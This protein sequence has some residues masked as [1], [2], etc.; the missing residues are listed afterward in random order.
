MAASAQL[1]INGTTGVVAAQSIIETGTTA[2]TNGHAV[3]ATNSGTVTNSGP[4]T[5]TTG[6]STAYGVFVQTGASAFFDNAT[7]TT[8]GATAYGLD[9]YNAGSE[10]RLRDSAV[11]TSGRGSNGVRAVGAGTINLTDV[12]VSTTGNGSYGIQSSGANSRVNAEGVTVQTTGTAEGANSSVGAIAEGGGTLVL[13]HSSANAT[14][15]TTA[16]AQASGLWAQTEGALVATG[17][18]RLLEVRT[19]GA[20]AYGAFAHGAGSSMSLTNVDIVTQGD[21]SQGVHADIGA[22]ITLT[23]DMQASRVTT[24]GTDSAGVWAENANASLYLANTDV[25]TSGQRAIGAGVANGARLEINGGSVLTTGEGAIGAMNN[26][27]TAV[28]ARSANGSGTVIGTRGESSHGI[29]VIANG[30][31]RADGATISTLGDLAA[32]ARAAAG[33]SLT[34]TNSTIVTEGSRGYGMTAIDPGSVIQ[35]NNVQVTTTGDHLGAI[36]AAGVVSEFGAHVAI[37][38]DSSVTT[39]GTRAIGLLS[40]VGGDNNQPD[41]VLTFNGGSAA[42]SVT[43]LG[44]MAHGAMVCSRSAGS[45]DCTAPLGNDIAGAGARASMDINGVS[46]ST[47]GSSAYGLVAFGQSAN[48]SAQHVRVDTAGQDAHASVVRNGGQVSIS[49]STLTATGANAA[50]VF[51]TGPADVNGTAT[52]SNVILSAAQGASV[53]VDGGTADLSLLNSKAQ[54]NDGRWLT[55]GNGQVADASV[56][57]ATLDASIV[58]GA[59]TTAVGSTS[60]VILRNDTDWEMTA[61]SNVSNLTNNDS[62]IRFSAPGGVPALAS[63]YKTLTVANYA[64]NGGDIG[65]NTYLGADG[66]PSDRLVVDGGAASGDTGLRIANTGGPG[67]HT[68]VNGIQVVEAANGGV[69]TAGAFTLRNRVVAGP[70]EYRLIRGSRDD[71]DEQGW[72][73]RS[74]QEVKPPVES[75]PEASPDKP[76][77]SA[78]RPLYRPE[79]AAYLANQ[80]QAIGMFVHSLHDRLGEPQWLQAGKQNGQEDRRGSAWMRV[81]AKT[82]DATSRH[83]DFGAKSDSTLIQGGGDIARWNIGGEHA[84]L[85]LGG[86]LGY[87]EARSDASATGNSAKARGKTEGWNVGA[88]GTWYQ[89]DENKLGWYADAWATYGRFKNTV[90]GDSMPQVRYDSDVLTLSAETGYA[91]KVRQDSDWIIEP[92]AQ[93]IFIRYGQDDVAE[94][95]GTRITD[96]NDRNGW[97]SRLGVR[98]HRTWETSSGKLIQPYLTLNW[99]RDNTSNALAFNGVT[100]G[101]LLPK[102]RYEAKAGINA[103]LGSGWSVWGNVGHQLGSQ[104]YSETT[105]RAGAKYTW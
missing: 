87:G 71:S 11:S 74:E 77:V 103:N 46:L 9:A 101:D 86:M 105:V 56:L 24:T 88:Y 99:W 22:S 17:D 61:N 75:T 20:N 1:R 104:S 72:Y 26:G 55:V 83:N 79:T 34:L 52:L 31:T 12:T 6:G 32:G 91:L 21:G 53:A 47:Q 102:N 80:Q 48:L 89:N 33:G 29:N 7:V 68:L 5:I 54:V 76:E 50:A 3:L 38:G 2:G 18:D 37:T 66:A 95:N 13:A 98:T 25:A 78:T 62:Q 49:D 51:M 81:V 82:A 27:G 35:A 43:T 14:S 64:G 39:K 4:I 65:L 85:H 100:V 10:I 40:Q 97:M 42:N 8:T 59:A 36:A 94:S 69:T 23:G 90:H 44:E 15:I 67:A 16:G 84:R 92:Q 45:P 70:Y 41:T 28:I 57:T 58:T 30:D 93:M 19:A 63:S 73:L 96:G 60:N